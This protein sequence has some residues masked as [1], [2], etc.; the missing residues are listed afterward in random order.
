MSGKVIKK[1]RLT[2]GGKTS[3]R[4]MVEWYSGMISEG[5]NHINANERRLV[6]QD[7]IKRGIQQNKRTEGKKV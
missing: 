7:I 1:M 6:I 5:G 3:Q 2:I 4:R